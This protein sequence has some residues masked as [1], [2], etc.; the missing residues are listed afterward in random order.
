V[1]L[2]SV[3]LTGFQAILAAGLLCFVLIWLSDEMEET[4]DR[5]VKIVSLRILSRFEGLVLIQKSAL[6]STVNVENRVSKDIFSLSL[7][8]VLV[9]TQDV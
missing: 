9:D 5:S 7:T 4:V 1:H 2:K 8:V 6:V 3:G